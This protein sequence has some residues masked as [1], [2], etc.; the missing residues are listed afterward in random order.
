FILKERCSESNEEIFLRRTSKIKSASILGKIESTMEAAIN[1]KK[2]KT[3][4][5][6]IKVY[7]KIKDG[8]WVY[9]G[10]FELKDAVVKK[11]AGRKVFKFKLYI[12]DKTV[13]LKLKRN[14]E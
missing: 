11:I 5:E 8:I 13:D 2:G 1:F 10:V 4:S 3:N 7:E 6:M 12:T 9:S 14:K